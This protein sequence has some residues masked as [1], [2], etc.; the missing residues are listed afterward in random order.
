MIVS[1]TL[2]A[3]INVEASTPLAP[4]DAPLAARTVDVLEDL[5]FRVG[6]PASNHSA[7]GEVLDYRSCQAMPGIRK[8]GRSLELC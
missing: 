4:V 1:A 2:Q 8:P 3:A 6:N 5:T 7:D